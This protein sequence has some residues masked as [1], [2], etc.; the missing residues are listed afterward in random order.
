MMINHSI[1]E[2]YDHFF[3][4]S[5]KLYIFRSFQKKENC[6]T[7]RV[8]GYFLFLFLIFGSFRREIEVNKEHK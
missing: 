6:G 2:E 3:F 8:S 5:I 1:Q 7:K 4:L